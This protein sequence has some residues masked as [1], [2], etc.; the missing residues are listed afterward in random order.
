TWPKGER[1]PKHMRYADEVMSGFEYSAAAAMVYAGLLR[2][3]F[4]IVRAAS[5]RYDG[6]LRTGLTGT[7]T[8]SWGYSG[9]PF[10]DDECGKFYARPMSIW[11][12]LLACQ[13]FVH[14]GPAGVIGFRPAWKADD[15]VSFFSGAEGWGLFT[16]KRDDDK[17]TEG[18]EVRYGKLRVKTL[19][20]ELPEG[21]KPSKV[22]VAIGD[23]AIR[24]QHASEGGILTISLGSE[25]TIG[26]GQNMTVVTQW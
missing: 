9:N 15:H 10:G 22:S 17:Q 12:M 21:A 24:S 8:A 2:E 14:D 25:V 7:D 6:R 3:G 23:R 5:I 13:G 18:I 4:T 1:P 16:Q 20:F 19:I 11:S 26:E